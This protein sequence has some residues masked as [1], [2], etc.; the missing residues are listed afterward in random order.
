MMLAVPKNLSRIEACINYQATK[1]VT[2]RSVIL[3][4][5]RIEASLNWA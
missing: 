3:F 5:H 4:R 1:G 2:G